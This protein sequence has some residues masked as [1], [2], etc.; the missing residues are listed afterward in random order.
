MIYLFLII[1]YKRAENHLMTNI[2]K[3]ICRKNSMLICKL[4]TYI[5]YTLKFDNVIFF[6][7]KE[8]V[9]SHAGIFNLLPLTS[10]TTLARN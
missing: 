5:N 6:I 10:D 8:P 3:K 7:A 2:K 1:N 4:G 9:S